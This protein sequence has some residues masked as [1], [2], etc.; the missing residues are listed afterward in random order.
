MKSK[1]YPGFND[2]MIIVVS[3][4][5]FFLMLHFPNAPVKLD[6]L[7]G[8]KQALCYS[9]SVLLLVSVLAIFPT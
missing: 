5:T 8:P 7:L 1:L 3:V 4:P 2:P 9:V 6:S